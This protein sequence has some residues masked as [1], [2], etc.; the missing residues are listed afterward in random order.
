[1]KK[2]FTR[3]LKEE[4]KIEIVAFLIDEIRKSLNDSS[5]ENKIPLDKELLQSLLQN[6]LENKYI[7]QYLKYIDLTGISFDTS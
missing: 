3:I 1:M 4:W 6:L 2:N 5:I 7:N